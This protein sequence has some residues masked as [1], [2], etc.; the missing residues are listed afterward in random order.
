MSYLERLKKDLKKDEFTVSDFL[1]YSCIL[2]VFVAFVVLMAT[3]FP[4]NWG[5]NPVVNP[6]ITDLE[7]NPFAFGSYA[8]ENGIS[9][10]SN[11]YIGAAGAVQYSEQWLMG[12]IEAKNKFELSQKTKPE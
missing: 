6:K 1:V 8:Y 12:W 7:N 11:P 5:P 3:L 10:S 4:P 2:I 9:D